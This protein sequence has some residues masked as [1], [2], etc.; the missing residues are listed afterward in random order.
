MKGFWS[1]V[2]GRKNFAGYVAVLLITVAWFYSQ[3]EFGEYWMP[4]LLALGITN[5]L[6]VAQKVVVKDGQ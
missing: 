3:A 6:N 5:G 1:A 2:G 4:I